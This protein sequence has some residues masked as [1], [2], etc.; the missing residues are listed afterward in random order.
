MRAKQLERTVLVSDAIAVAGLPPGRYQGNEGQM[1]EIAPNGRI[2]VADTPYLAGSGL[3]LHQGIGNAVRF[4]GISLAGAIRLATENPARVFGVADSYGRLE[5]GH[6]ADLLLF[7][8]DE[9]AQDVSV[10]ATIAAGEVVY[11]GGA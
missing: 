1:L 7:R 11:R 6:S 4:A 10:A 8:W 5:P 2:G 9:A 3:R